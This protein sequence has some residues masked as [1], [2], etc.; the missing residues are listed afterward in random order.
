MEVQKCSIVINITRPRGVMAAHQTS[1][2][3][4]A[5]S[6]PVEVDFLR[7]SNL[8]IYL[9]STG[10]KRG[11]FTHIVTLQIMQI[12]IFENWRITNLISQ[13]FNLSIEIPL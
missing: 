6:I 5:G 9:G 2:L 10:F 13:N 8:K 11:G 12:H 4:V 3:G 7:N 1:D